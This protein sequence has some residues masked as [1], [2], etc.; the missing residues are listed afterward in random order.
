MQLTTLW[1]VWTRKHFSSKFPISAPP[2]LQVAFLLY[3]HHHHKLVRDRVQ[4]LINVQLWLCKSSKQFHSPVLLVKSLKHKKYSWITQLPASIWWKYLINRCVSSS[5]E[6]SGVASEIIEQYLTSLTSPTKWHLKY[7]SEFPSAFLFHLSN[8]SPI[9]SGWF[10]HFSIF[11]L[12]PFISY[13]MFSVYH[14]WSLDRS[15]WI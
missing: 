14:F 6:L 8:L 10:Y 2:E 3:W 15:T 13:N 11:F 7:A 4:T 1:L 12:S 9:M 5:C